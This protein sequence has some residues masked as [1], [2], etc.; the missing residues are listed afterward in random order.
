VTELNPPQAPAVLTVR[1]GG[2]LV[3]ALAE[4]C[5]E[6][7]IRYGAMQYT[8]C[9][10][11]IKSTFTLSIEALRLL[12]ELSKKKGLSKSSILELAIRLL[13]EQENVQ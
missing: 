6:I 2:F 4:L 5:F 11:K 9:M 12:S 7:H 10:N 13:A 1:I 8:I 3:L